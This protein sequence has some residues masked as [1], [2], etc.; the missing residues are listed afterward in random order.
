MVTWDNIVEVAKI[1]PLITAAVASLAFAIAWRQLKT[2]RQNEA[3]RQFVSFLDASAN[4]ANIYS[5]NRVLDEKFYDKNGTDFNYGYF[6]LLAKGL[7]SFEEILEQFPNDTAWRNTI[8]GHLEMHAGA[9][10]HVEL[11]SYSLA[12][13]RMIGEVVRESEIKSKMIEN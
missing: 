1:G 4:M 12:L 11:E 7:M 8:K 10:K 5:N 2:V 9:F 3:K 6:V 13:Q